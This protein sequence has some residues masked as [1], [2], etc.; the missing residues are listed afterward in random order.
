MDDPLEELLEEECRHE[1]TGA[2]L[3]SH[4]Q[5]KRKFLGTMEEPEFGERVSLCADLME[6]PEVRERVPLCAD[7]FHRSVHL[8]LGKIH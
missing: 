1:L 6:E 4:R 2:C 7:L 8:S 3:Q 5:S